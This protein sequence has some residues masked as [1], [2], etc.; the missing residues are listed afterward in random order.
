V[1]LPEELVHARFQPNGRIDIQPVGVA[2]RT[3]V[4][5]HPGSAAAMLGPLLE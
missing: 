4:D 2:R 3:A 1:L 5:A